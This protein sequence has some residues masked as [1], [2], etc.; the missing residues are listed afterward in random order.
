M[1]RW[2]MYALLAAATAIPSFAWASAACCP[3]CPGCPCG[4]K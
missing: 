4:S 1:K 3:D 2:M